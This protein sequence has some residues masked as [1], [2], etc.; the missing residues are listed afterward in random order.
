MLSHGVSLS[1]QE[2]CRRIKRG[3]R[4]AASTAM[5]LVGIWRRERWRASVQ[6]NQQAAAKSSQ[7]IVLNETIVRKFVAADF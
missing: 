7:I 4:R 3:L 6:A 5:G 2:I 1:K